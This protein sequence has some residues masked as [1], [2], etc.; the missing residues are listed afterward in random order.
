M[1]GSSLKNFIVIL[2]TIAIILLSYVV[3]RS[4]M[5]RN[6]REKI[7]KQDSLNVRLNRIEAKLVKIQELTAQDRIVRYAQDS[8]GLIR[9]KTNPEIIIV[10]KDQVYQIEKILNEKYD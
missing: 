6:T 3:V 10:S 5:K 2:T 8:L 4:E 7:F 9:P 1:K